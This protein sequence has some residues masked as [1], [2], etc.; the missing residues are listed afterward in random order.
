MIENGE[1]VTFVDTSK[2]TNMEGMFKGAESFNQDISNWDTSKVT[3]MSYM[4][5][6]AKSFNQDISGW[7]IP[8]NT[9]MFYENYFMEEK[10]K[11]KIKK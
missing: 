2:V 1:D 6:N 5:D 9:K 8:T 10:N 7:S 11:P 4:F 3:N